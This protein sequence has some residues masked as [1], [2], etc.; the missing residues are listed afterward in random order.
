MRPVTGSLPR[1]NGLERRGAVRVALPFL[2]IVRGREPTGDR[3][4]LEAVLDNLSS[5][6]LY[7]RLARAV[8]PGA[9]LFIVIRLAIAPADQ[10]A[11]PSVAVHGVVLRAELQPGGM[12]GIAVVFTSHRFLYAITT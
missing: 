4:T 1:C 8:A 6:G 11:A 9:S 3:F 7:L 2:A 12:Y 10:V 5:S